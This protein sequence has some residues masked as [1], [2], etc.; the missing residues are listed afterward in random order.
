MQVCKKDQKIKSIFWKKTLSLAKL[1][2][3]DY[4]PRAPE[5]IEHIG[6]PATNALGFKIKTEKRIYFAI[7]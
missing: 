6:R 5:F 7:K 2:F 1:N 4:V 3:F